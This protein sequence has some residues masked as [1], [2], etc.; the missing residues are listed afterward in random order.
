M[1]EAREP[2]GRDQAK[3]P[4][5]KAEIVTVPHSIRSKVSGGG[6]LSDEMLEKAENVI[7]EHGADY[8]TRAQA[9]I[10]SL[11]QTVRTARE[12]VESRPELFGK[13]FQKSHDI[14][15]M[16]STFGYDLVTEIGASLCNFVEGLEQHDDDAMEVVGAHVDAL[17]A[18]IANGVK[19]DGGAIGREI[20]EGL[21]QAVAQAAQRSE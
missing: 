15:G 1:A 8:V 14:R 11:I 10:E 12:K 21:A 19:G 4:A 20:A 16:G 5:A 2:A 17:R 13:I 7:E 6:P 9:Q 3:K 18:V